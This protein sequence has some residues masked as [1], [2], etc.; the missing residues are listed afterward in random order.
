M[1]VRWSTLMSWETSSCRA[2]SEVARQAAVC[3][4]FAL[5]AIS[6]PGL[7]GNLTRRRLKG[8]SRPRPDDRASTLKSIDSGR[9]FLQS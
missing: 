2:T 6:R 8:V 4:A 1:Q 5:L 3:A 9:R 7:D